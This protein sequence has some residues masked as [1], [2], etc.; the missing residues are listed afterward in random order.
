MPVISRLKDS[1]GN[2]IT[3]YNKSTISKITMGGID[4]HFARKAEASGTCEDAV[5]EPLINLKIEGNSIQGLPEEYQQVEY[6]ESSGTQYINTGVVADQNTSA[7][8]DF[9][10]LKTES[11]FIFGSRTSTTE[12]AYTLSSGNSSTNIVSAYGT[13]SNVILAK[14]DLNRHTFRKNKYVCTLDDTTLDAGTASMVFTT[15]GPL[16]LFAC[17]QTTGPYLYST[18][19]IFEFKLWQSDRLV[20]DMVPCY[21][22]EDKVAGFYDLV[23]GT[24]YTNKGTGSFSIGTDIYPTIDKPIEI[25]SVGE[26]TRNLFDIDYSNIQ[27]C[28]YTDTAERWGYDIG[29]LSAGDYNFSFELVDEAD[30]PQSVYIRKKSS[31]GTIGAGGTLTT[32]VV[33]NNPLKFT[34]DGESNYYLVCA[35]GS[36]ATL[37]QAKERIGKFKWIQLEL[38]S[39]AKEYEP[40][41]YKIPIKIQA[42][43]LFDYSLLTTYYTIDDFNNIR[44][45]G[46]NTA[47]WA[48][49]NYLQL[50]PLTRTNDLNVK[51]FREIT[52]SA[53]FITDDTGQIKIKLFSPDSAYPYYIG[54]IQ[55][56]E[57]SSTTYPI[58]HNIYLKEP[59]RKFREYIDILNLKEGKVIR[60]VKHY[61]FTGDEYCSVS[62]K[63]P[64]CAL[65]N[66]PQRFASQTIQPRLLCDRLISDGKREVGKID[67]SYTTGEPSGSQIVL[68]LGYETREEVVAYIMDQY[69]KRT[70]VYVEYSLYEPEEEAINFIEIP[71]SKG[72]NVFNILTLIQPNN[73]QINY[74]KQI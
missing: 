3:K 69:N 30:I 24:F 37:E 57:G 64:G 44:I 11:T 14:L 61:E 72:L 27:R 58:I 15:P 2:D 59:L 26:R 43:N 21:R 8:V 10:Y 32:S 70:P 12:K 71:T 49:M 46:S 62:S 31:D 74:W 1:Q 42:N 23:E 53:T 65:V 48:T 68:G 38:G 22:K 60:N 66:V 19:R 39:T 5:P 33:S 41:G 52:T 47:G 7:Y 29:I 25:Q 54:W 63:S 50:K 17:Y 20:R 35:S 18:S 4:Y 28:P 51:L 9:Q 6:I 16:Y 67:M 45:T 40:H 13:S 34:A 36:V 56:E 55:L 73:L